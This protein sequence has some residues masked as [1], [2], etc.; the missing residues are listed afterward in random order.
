MAGLGELHRLFQVFLRLQKTC[1][2]AKVSFTSDSDGD[3][4]VSL[5][6]KTP[7]HGDQAPRRGGHHSRSQE[8]GSGNQPPPHPSTRV[9]GIQKPLPSP[10]PV[11][12]GRRRAPSALLRDE[13]RR[14]ARIEFD[15]LCEV[16]GGTALPPP[17][18]AA[19]PAH[20]E[21]DKD[22]SI[23]AL[24]EVESQVQLATPAPAAPRSCRVCKLP[25]KG[26]SGPT[27]HGKCSVPLSSPLEQL[28]D[29]QET[30]PP[31]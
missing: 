3:I 31:L 19:P 30:Y 16:E 28:L 11:K 2:Q 20:R 27:G 18:M 13:R 14:L 7:G 4:H 25:V 9:S 26:H 10:V 6:V 5:T 12:K 22:S 23:L 29:S 21:A 1:K 17:V 15:V 24:R 8:G